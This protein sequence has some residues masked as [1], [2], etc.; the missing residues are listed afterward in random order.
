MNLLIGNCGGLQP[1]VEL[2]ADLHPVLHSPPGGRRT[3]PL[4]A[5]L[6]PHL[7]P[8]GPELKQR[9]GPGERHDQAPAQTEARPTRLTSESHTRLLVASSS[10]T[11]LPAQPRPGPRPHLPYQAVLY[12]PT[13]LLPPQRY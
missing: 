9:P 12:P 6:L 10:N 7:L 2:P 4:P 13:R 1:W 5:D 3:L 11:R 8:P